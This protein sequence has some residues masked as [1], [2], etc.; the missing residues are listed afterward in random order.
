MGTR[1]ND[2]LVDQVVIEQ[3][4]VIQNALYGGPGGNAEFQR[5]MDAEAFHEALVDA[6]HA[7]KELSFGIIPSGMRLRDIH[8]RHG[9]IVFLVEM[10]PGTRTVRW[11]RDDSPEE[12][13]SRATY[14]D[15]TIAF[16]WQYF[17]ISLTRDG[18]ILSLNSVYFRNEPLK[19]L[20]DPLRD[21]HYFNCS[22]DAYGAHCWICAGGAQPPGNARLSHA[23]RVE[24]F[25][26]WF[27]GSGFNKS[28]EHHEGAS[29]WGK[30][31]H[32]IGD[33]RVRTI[34]AWEKASRKDGRFALRV[35]WMASGYT[36][37]TVYDELTKQVRPFA[38]SCAR[39]WAS[40][41]RRNARGIRRKEEHHAAT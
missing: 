12:F 22:V 15:V 19:G 36:P 20:D 40:F 14:R 18:E 39:D 1:Q 27:F 35:P 24:W 16:P 33:K 37:R 41:V 32:R 2:H 10:E 30:N 26:D 8:E 17:F 34:G 28:S 21:C 11:I 5:E 6:Y 23:E 31:R 29:F 7:Q 25:I 4:R 13:G 3:N 9:M 38:P